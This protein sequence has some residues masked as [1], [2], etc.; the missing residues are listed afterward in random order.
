MLV[1]KTLSLQTVDRELDNQSIYTHSI[2]NLLS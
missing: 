1:R 2:K